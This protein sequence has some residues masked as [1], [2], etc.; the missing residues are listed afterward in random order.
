[1]CI[2]VLCI[3]ELH[4]VTIHINSISVLCVSLH[5]YMC[6]W[7]CV[8]W[9]SPGV[10]AS[11]VCWRN[12][13]RPRQ[14]N[15]RSCMLMQPC[16]SPLAARQWNILPSVEF[17]RHDGITEMCQE[18]LCLGSLSRSRWLH[19]PHI[20]VSSDTHTQTHKA[21]TWKV[22]LDTQQRAH[23]SKH[24]QIHLHKLTH[25]LL[26]LLLFMEERST[27]TWVFTV[28]MFFGHGDIYTKL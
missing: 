27:A 16:Y 3:L 14:W 20:K 9:Q 28:C 13:T 8:L 19:Q 21:T 1:M 18:A 25:C 2:C 24:R 6:A 17:P 5:I 11:P 4:T 15:H 10:P 22:L 26:L 12:L 7:V 23:T